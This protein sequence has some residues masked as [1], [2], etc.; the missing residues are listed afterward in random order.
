MG[1]TVGL[2]LHPAYVQIPLPATINTKDGGMSRGDTEIAYSYLG[3]DSGG[4]RI[5]I[6]YADTVDAYGSM[7]TPF[8]TMNVIRQKHW[9]ITV[10]SLGLH[11]I[12]GWTWS[13]D[14]HH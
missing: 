10:D 2:T 14:Y 12:T 8:G 6:H 7:T 5:N 11:Y 4:A 9:D 1:L 13:A 3:S